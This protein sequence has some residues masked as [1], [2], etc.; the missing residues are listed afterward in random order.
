[1]CYGIVRILSHHVHH[2]RSSVG[3]LNYGFPLRERKKRTFN[4]LEVRIN[5]HVATF[6]LIPH[7]YWVIRIV[8]V[9]ASGPSSS[10]FYSFPPTTT[11]KSK[12]NDL[13]TPVNR[14]L[15]IV[16]RLLNLVQSLTLWSFARMFA[17]FF[18][19]INFRR[20]ISSCQKLLDTDLICNQRNC[21]TCENYIISPIQKLGQFS[22]WRAISGGRTKQIDRLCSLFTIYCSRP[23]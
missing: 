21:A 3:V 10:T 20:Q 1:M 8:K 6:C 13:H 15:T 4:R 5:L 22:F 18:P 12:S 16:A 2:V 17:H 23:H 11:T 9:R 19:R 7:L 14:T